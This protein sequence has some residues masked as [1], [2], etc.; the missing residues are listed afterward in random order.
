M[1]LS[2]KFIGS[3]ATI[4]HLNLRKQGSED[5]RVL[6]IDIKITGEA[7]AAILNDLLGASADE[8]VSG[9]FWST[10]PG[11]DPA[12]LKSYVIG[13]I[14]V[15]GVW[16]N[17]IVRFGKQS[18]VGDLKKI[19]FKPM[20]GQRLDITASISIEEPKKELLDY[21]VSKITENVLC[22]IESQPELAL[23][24]TAAP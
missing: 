2:I 12:S 23:A 10:A 7:P 6:A 14:D 17:R 5:D 4:K 20:P 24:G 1:A 15:D 22:D 21:L 16:P 3:H 19:A 11:A 8:N 9:M 18:A 13:Q